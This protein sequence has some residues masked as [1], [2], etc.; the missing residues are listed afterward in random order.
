MEVAQTPH[1]ILKMMNQYLKD[2]RSQLRI[3]FAEDSV[4]MSYSD[5]ILA[6][7]TL[8]KKP[9]SFEGYEFQQAIVDDMSPEMYVIKC[10]QIGL[11]EVQLRKFAGFLARNTGVNAIFTLPDDNMYKRVSQT[12]FGPMI[13]KDN[14]FN[15][16]ADKPIRS[17]SLYQINQSFGYF[18]GN[19][20]SDATS[21]NADLLFHDELDLSNQEMIALFQSRLQGSDFRITQNFST[22]T[23]EGFGVD[24][25][26]RISDQHEYMIK[27]T[28]CGHHNLPAFNPNHVVIPGLSSDVNDLLEIDDEMAENLDLP[29]SYVK[30]EKC[31]NKL[32][33]IDPTLR[34]WVPRFPGR[35]AR[36]YRVS[37]FS[38][39]RL[40][41]G[42]IVDQLLQYRRRDAMRRFHNT[43]LGEAY[44]DN[45]ARLS[46]LELRAIMNGVGAAD[47][48]EFCPV[49]VGIDVGLTCH[50]TL[51]HLGQ[52]HPIAFSWR[53][54]TA[55]T[56]Y[57]EVEQILERYNVIGGLIDRNPYTPLANDIR[58][59]SGGRILP[60][61]YA[62]PTAATLT[63]VK[64]EFDE[65]SHVKINRTTALDA[66]TGAIRKRKIEFYGY[67]QYESQLIDHL[68]DMVRIENDEKAAIWQKLTGHDHFFHSA[69]YGYFSMRM[70]DAL[71]YRKD[72]DTRS[73]VLTD[74]VTMENQIGD[75][76]GVISRLKSPMSL[77][78]L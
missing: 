5:W 49:I 14:V 23:F 76:L 22:P 73:L 53:Q 3:R 68:R 71:D 63:F 69:S 43:V 46:E 6:N 13:A 18:V 24:A 7:T 72:A 54:V 19:K 25:G 41:V 78:T 17:M 42:Y 35:R 56:L 65:L 44:N 9:F 20:E 37:P 12:R 36:G 31:G 27:C 21:I 57:N 26:F 11:T 4:D 77:G 45:N 40:T 64:D 58:D 74:T 75:S 10:S 28:C 52:K 55:D 62:L 29:G 60:A 15:L 32:D 51:Y 59:L 50:I 1:Y 34:Q 48:D 67:G 2:F 8:R 38:T 30:C 66:L 33:M 70:L 47:V 61:E 16:G 39:P